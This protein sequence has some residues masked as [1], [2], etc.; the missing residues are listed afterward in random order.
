MLEVVA[1]LLHPNMTQLLFQPIQL[2]L[3]KLALQY[4]Q[5][6]KTFDVL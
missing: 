4:L 2:T 5:L 1:D 3:L 6:D